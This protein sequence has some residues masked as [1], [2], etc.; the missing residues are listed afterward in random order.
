ME[1][2]VTV[3]VK[4]V[5][6]EPTRGSEGAAAFD[7]YAAEDVIVYPGEVVKVKTGTKIA[8]PDGFEGLINVRSSVGAKGLMLANGTGVIDSDYRGELIVALYNGNLKPAVGLLSVGALELE[9]D[10][11]HCLVASSFPGAIEIHEGDRIGQLRVR[12]V[13][14]V[15]FEEAETLDDTVRGEGGFGSTGV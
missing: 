10:E 3:V 6:T 12:P 9:L 8:V 15:V 13:P 11:N 5:G 4:Y 14:E 2:P 7:L 1:T